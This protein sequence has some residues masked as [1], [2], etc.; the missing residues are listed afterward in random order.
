MTKVCSGDTPAGA[1]MRRLNQHHIE[2][3]FYDVAAGE[4]S[5]EVGG[6]TVTISGTDLIVVPDRQ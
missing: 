2:W 1:N 3:S 5:F 6:Q 4:G